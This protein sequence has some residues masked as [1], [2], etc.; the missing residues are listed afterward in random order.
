MKKLALAIVAVCVAAPTIAQK[1]N[2]NSATR[3][4]GLKEYKQALEYI[5]E[6]VEDPSTKDDPK[7]WYVRGS[8]YMNMQQ[9]PGYQDQDPYK[10]GVN[11]Y[12]KVV[13]LDPKYKADEI[14]NSLLF[15]AYK[16]YNESVMAF[17]A[18]KFDES[19]NLADKTITIHGLDGGQRFN[20]PGFDTVAAGALAIKGLSAFYGQ[21]PDI[22]MVVLND[23]KDNPIE[24]KPNVYLMIAELHRN[25][26]NKNKE[27]VII[28]EARTKF[29]GDPNVRNEELNYYI[30]NNMQ[31][32][33][34]KKLKAAVASDP[35]NPIYQYNLANVYSNMA[36]AKEVPENYDVLVIESENGFKKAL[37]SDPDNPGYNYDIGALYFNMASK[38]TDKMNEITGTTAEDDKKYNELKKIRDG[39][40]DKALP[41]LEKVYLAFDSKVGELNASDREL[42]RSAVI[43]MREI[44]ARQNKLDKAAEMKKKLEQ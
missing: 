8:I 25:N 19:I 30:R 28:E 33:L 6:A 12:L 31:D 41:Y 13:E 1:S 18:K 10:E 42:Y 9:D 35:D 24:S 21:K 16:F 43:A 2:I 37:A 15:G 32:E 22:A 23:L 3:S 11:S 5:N 34:I 26:G 20:N 29:P 40:F 7:A 36:F 4:L 44:Y 39:Y 17:N 27:L 14:N 38:V